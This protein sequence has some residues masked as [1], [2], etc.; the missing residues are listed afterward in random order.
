[1]KLSVMNMFLF[2]E[3]R[4]L[5]CFFF[6]YVAWTR[7]QFGFHQKGTWVRMYNV[8]AVVFIYG[9]ISMESQR[10]LHGFSYARK[11]INS[12]LFVRMVFLLNSRTIVVSGSPLLLTSSVS[13]HPL[14]FRI[15]S[16]W[17]SAP[18]DARCRSDMDLTRWTCSNLTKLD[19]TTINKF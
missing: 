13:S 17:L 3:K 12:V 8:N 16:T 10:M 4:Y 11:C 15:F 2:T 7:F 9:N 18:L 14:V 19:I 5:F 1:M 6:L